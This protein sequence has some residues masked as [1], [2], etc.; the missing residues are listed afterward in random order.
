MKKSSKP[1]TKARRPKLPPLSA[2]V[3]EARR[4][5]PPDVLVSALQDTVH[6]EVGISRVARTVRTKKKKGDGT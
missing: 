1:Q 3:E 6:R 2:E 4:P 5:L